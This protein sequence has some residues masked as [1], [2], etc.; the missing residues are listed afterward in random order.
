M[1]FSARFVIPNKSADTIGIDLAKL[2][3]ID[4]VSNKNY[5][6]DILTISSFNFERPFLIEV[7]DREFC[8]DKIVIRGWFNYDYSGPEPYL[9]KGALE[10]RTVLI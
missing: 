6:K 4:A 1:K 8:E 2:Y 7:V 10:L 3:V 5:E 9:F